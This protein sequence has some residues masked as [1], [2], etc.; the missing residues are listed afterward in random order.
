MET[1]KK[2]KCQG[3]GQ[4]PRII[5]NNDWFIGKTGCCPVCNKTICLKKK[6]NEYVYKM[7]THFTS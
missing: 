1:P 7:P 2:K 3:S 6:D 4:E 5:I